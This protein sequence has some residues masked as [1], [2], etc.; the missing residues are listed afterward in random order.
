MGVNMKKSSILFLG[1]TICTLKLSN[2]VIVKASTSTN[3]K[4]NQK[5]NS[6]LIRNG[7]N[8]G[9]TG[10]NVSP[11]S[12]IEKGKSFS[13]LFKTEEKIK[14]KN[15]VNEFYKGGGWLYS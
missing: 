12:K 10:L 11:S 9:A 3:R 2:T 14:G 15:N 4:M 1:M 7:T 6:T 5:G 13:D 8:L